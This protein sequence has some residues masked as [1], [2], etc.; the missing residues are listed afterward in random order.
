MGG[1][2]ALG[3]GRCIF[4]GNVKGKRRPRG[5]AV[6]CEYC[7]FC[8]TVRIGNVVTQYRKSLSGAI[9]IMHHT[10]ARQSAQPFTSIFIQWGLGLALLRSSYA[11]S[12]AWSLV[13]CFPKFPI[14]SHNM[15]D[16][17]TTVSIPL[18]AFRDVKP[19]TVFI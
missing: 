9:R 5:D 7:F 10:T 15:I 1:N 19:M 16:R 17:R 4:E 2:P 18:G 14:Q 3:S 8:E 13:L 6:T 11:P 12:N